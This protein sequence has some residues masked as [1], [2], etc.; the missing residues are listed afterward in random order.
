MMR[1]MRE[2]MGHQIATAELFRLSPPT[3]GE[4]IEV[5]GF[6]HSYQTWNP[7]PTL[8]LAKGEANQRLR[9]WCKLHY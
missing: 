2:S 5:R 9:L 3:I 4:R 8:S 6:C 7:H 1:H